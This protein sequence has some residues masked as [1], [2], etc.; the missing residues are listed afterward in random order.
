MAK[1]TLEKLERHLFAAADILRGKMDAS[2]FKEYIFGILFLKRCSDVFEQQRDKIL[3]E[4]RAL[5]RTEDEALQRADHPSSYAKTFFVPTVA[6][7]QRLL[8]D[9][10]SNVANELN[11][12][13]AGLEN[14]NHQALSGVL[15][16]INFARKVG[17]SEIPDEKLRRLISHFNK[18]RL[19]DEDFEFPDLLGAAYE[20]LIGEFA[21]S[22]GKK[23][24]EFYTPRGVVQLMVRILDP[25][26]GTS[27]YDPTC[28]SGGMLNQGNEHAL[29]HGGP[30]LRLYGQEDNGAVWAICRMNLLLHGIPDADIRN[31]DTL[32]DPKHIE[33]GRLMRFD[34]VI[35]NP[36]FSQNYTKRG[37]QF[38]DRFRFG[39]CPTT[40]KK[41]DLMFAQ[42]MLA[43]LKQTGKMAVVMP[44]GVLFRGGEEKKIRLGMLGLKGGKIVAD[45][46]CIEAVIGLP[47]NL[48]Y[49]TGIPAC[50]L[51]LRHSGSKPEGRKGKVLFINADR[52][53]REGRAQNFIDPEHIEKIISAYDAFIDVPGFAKVVDAKT[54][55]EDEAGNLNIRRF[56][57]SSPPPEPHDVRA[58][59]HG[60]VPKREIEGTRPYAEAQGFDVSQP[61]A[62]RDADYADF[63]TTLE[64]R[65]DLRALVEADAGVA[66]RQSEMVGAFDAW[67]DSARSGL[68][69]LPESKRLMPL[70]RDL[71]DS[72]EPA[73]LPVGCVDR[74][75]LMGSIA[76]WWDE[77][78]YEL[79]V[80][81]ENGFAEL[82]DGWV[83]T[84]RSALED[85][86]AD[87]DEDS[88]AK[89]TVRVTLE[90][91][92]AHPFVRHRMA[93]YVTEL[94]AA[95][96]EVERIKAEKEAWE[97]GDGVE[98]A[99]D[100]LDGAEEGTTLPKVLE[101]RRK[102]L[103]AEMGE[104]DKR[105]KEL[106]KTT[107][108][109]KPSKGSIDWMRAQRMDVREVVAELTD[110]ERRLAPLIEE[111]E[112]IDAMLA[113]YEAIKE[114][115][116][117]AR[118]TLR[119]LKAAFVERLTAA[120]AD[121]DDDDCCELVLDIDRER[122]LDRLER[123]RGHRVGALV[124]GLERLWDK[125]R[126]SLKKIEE[127]RT[128]AAT[129]LNGYLKELRYA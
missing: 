47:Q 51:I 97:T 16:H 96:A 70:R 74:Y 12:A 75:A 114:E 69:N 107:G 60:G 83:E 124:A 44:H 128:D 35:A 93:D 72:F 13:L 95:Q 106:V 58:H 42:H 77:I 63:A 113:P 5:G 76:G 71:L 34:R 103:R 127:Q 105:R 86:D 111:A 11:K 22:A 9:V 91:L 20:Y 32:L 29:Q 104:D 40:G 7:W 79:R 18:Y 26:G 126:V 57:D 48:F 53:Y 64:K 41:A 17:E 84:L 112:I 89:K 30:R 100:W 49:G 120:R 3:R 102:E 50:V 4:Q 62:D 43:T 119:R 90:E 110:L 123:A 8:N 36:P 14:S 2:E 121:L 87:D 101:K 98:G 59:L 67:W 108:T 88:D 92:L 19:L 125:Y 65:A 94:S 109:G 56:A 82:V 27:L 73:M 54:I 61:F 117:A 115:M 45:E 38:S 1:L 25:Q 78:R 80:I 118:A 52:E 21:D 28:G 68:A 122:L 39:W 31:G 6:R 10:H 81:V 15:G 46:D 55:I 66:A 129:L 33:D 99:E 37:I 23:A 116:K 24:G 85:E